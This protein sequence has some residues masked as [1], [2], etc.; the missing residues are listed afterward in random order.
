MFCFCSLFI[1]TDS[2]LIRYLKICWTDLRQ[3]FW[4]GRTITVDDSLKLA[5]WALKGHYH[6][7]QFLWL[8]AQLGV[9]MLGFA[10]NLVHFELVNCCL[11]L[12]VSVISQSTR[13]FYVVAARRHWGGSQSALC[14]QRGQVVRSR[15]TWF[16]AEVYREASSASV[17]T[18]TGSLLWG[19]AGC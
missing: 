7:N 2:C 1:F 17:K 11:Q 16:A 10:L 19:S 12:L 3:I 5:F 14:L 18:G 13:S 8:V 4:I 6:S 15:V 9:L